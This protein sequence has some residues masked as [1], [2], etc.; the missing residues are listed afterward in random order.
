MQRYFSNITGTNGSA[1]SGASITVRNAAGALATIY[2]DDGVNPAAN[3]LT[4]DVNGFFAFYAANGVYTLTVTGTG[5]ATQTITGVQLLD[6]DGSDGSASVGF[7]QSGT[8]AVARTMQD[9]GR[10]V[11]S[12]LDFGA[13]P[14]NADNASAF[15]LAAAALSSGATLYFPPGNYSYS[16]GL[17]FSLPVTLRGENGAILNYTGTGKAVTLGPTNIT[18]IGSAD[19]GSYVVDG[20]TFTGGASMTH[21]IY[22]PSWVLFPKIKNNKFYRF[23]NS[24]AYCVFAQGQNWQVLVEGNEFLNDQA[25][26]RNFLRTDGYAAGSGYDSGNSHLTCIGN[27][28]S[29]TSGYSVGVGIS[30]TGAGD[31]I[32]GNKIEGFAPNIRSGSSANWSM[33]SENYFEV[34][35]GNCIEFGDLSGGYSPSSYVSGIVI[36]DNYCN[37]HALDGTGNTGSFV[38]RTTGNEVTGIKFSR[39]INN[40]LGSCSTVVPIVLLNNVGSQVGNA[41][42]G[43]TDGT[44]L[45]PAYLRS[46]ANNLTAWAGEGVQSLGLAGGVSSL[47]SPQVASATLDSNNVVHLCGMLKATS[48][49]IPAN[50]TLAFLPTGYFPSRALLIPVY[51]VATVTATYLAISNTGGISCGISLA[52]TSQLD[53]NGVSFSINGL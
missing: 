4:A 25:V 11:L 8:G 52:S 31:I 28:I 18:A 5:I 40:K 16:G 1:V 38:A 48:A 45:V 41:G 43:N 3:P 46:I 39:V 29:A 47:A 20:L 2:T 21:G 24:T 35:S 27:N 17:S 37:M 36:E 50:T 53:L 34:I 30:H 49:S 33:I 13:S 26:A 22:I 42:Y 7:I 51:D 10:E 44:N 32:V 12:V 14:A 23:G 15:A 19:Y 6:V 9:K